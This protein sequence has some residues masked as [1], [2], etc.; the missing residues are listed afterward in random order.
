M[1]SL[2]SLV[3]TKQKITSI[4]SL[5]LVALA[6]PLHAVQPILENTTRK[7][8]DYKPLVNLFHIKGIN[9]AIIKYIDYKAEGEQP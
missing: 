7:D 3:M 4:F 5:L 9:L 8:S 1:N 2:N 6:S